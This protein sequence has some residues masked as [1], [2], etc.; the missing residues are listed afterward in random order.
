MVRVGARSAVVVGFVISVLVS[1]LRESMAADAESFWAAQAW[2][3]KYEVSF[4]SKTEGKVPV[5]VGSWTY[6]SSL[7]WSFSGS[8]LLDLRSEGPSISMTRLSLE[9]DPSSPEFQQATME[10][11][12]QT[13][14]IANW[15][16]MGPALDE[17]A[18]A[19]A[20][21]AQMMAA[22]EA[23]KGPGRLEYART[24]TK[25]GMISEM[26]TVYN[27][28]VRTTASGAGRVASPTQVM[29]EINTNTMTYL[30]MAPTAAVD[31]SANLVTENV[32]TSTVAK[33]EEPSESRD[34]RRFGLDLQVRGTDLDEPKTVIG[35]VPL[36]AGEFDPALGKIAGERT[37]TG[38]YDYR[39][40]KIPGSILIKYTLTPR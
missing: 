20:Q 15:M 8:L 40:M 36:L 1:P 29:F 38:S 10:L 16:C 25:V 27:E 22:R 34:T 12:Y 28:T 2:D 26:G 24:D 23:G 7:D 39:G 9:M 32:V 6:T 14:T 4:K 13:S 31:D 18:S 19:E 17:N 21:I 5:E 3:L 30:L 37:L 35:D 11:V 33:G